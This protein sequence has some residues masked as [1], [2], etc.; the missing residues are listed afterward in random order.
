[1][2][3]GLGRVSRPQQERDLWIGQNS[4]ARSL[5][6][7]LLWFLGVVRKGFRC[8]A[9]VERARPTQ[10]AAVG[11]FVFDRIVP[12]WESRSSCRISE[13]LSC[14][15]T[16]L[17]TWSTH[18]VLDKANGACLSPDR[19]RLRTGTCEWMD[20]MDLNA[21]MLSRVLSVSTSLGQSDACS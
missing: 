17:H 7:G 1:M 10:T 2:S 6:A 20:Q 14:A 9:P 5:M 3:W 18:S 13:T 21:H 8:G 16:S 4:L 12:G 15:A 11:Q 19:E